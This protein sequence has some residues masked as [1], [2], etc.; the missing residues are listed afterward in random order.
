VAPSQQRVIRVKQQCRAEWPAGCVANSVVSNRQARAA[1]KAFIKSKS[2]GVDQKHLGGKMRLFSIAGDPSHRHILG[3]GPQ[4]GHRSTDMEGR[5]SPFA[6]RDRDGRKGK[7]RIVY[8]LLLNF[9]E[10]W[11]LW[12]AG[13]SRAVTAYRG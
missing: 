11:D 8:G 2:L 5:C 4:V 10:W 6:Q 13:R 9:R 7:L 3:L 12:P 1:T